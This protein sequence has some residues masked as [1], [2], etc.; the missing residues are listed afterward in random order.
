MRTVYPLFRNGD[1]DDWDQM[2]DINVKGLLYV[3]REIMP[4]MIEPGKAAAL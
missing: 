1:T 3:S 4:G 2:I